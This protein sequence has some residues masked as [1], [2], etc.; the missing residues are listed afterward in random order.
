MSLFSH[1]LAYAGTDEARIEWVDQSVEVC[2]SAATNLVRGMTPNV[3]NPEVVAGA[4]R[5][6]NPCSCTSGPRT[7]LYCAGRLPHEQHSVITTKKGA[8]FR[9]VWIDYMPVHVTSTPFAAADLLIERG[10]T[11]VSALPLVRS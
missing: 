4:V 6:K 9:Y 10:W 7:R 1:R 3:E 2:G 11:R 8:K 5:N